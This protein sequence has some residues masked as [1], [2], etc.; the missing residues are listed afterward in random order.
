MTP[1]SSFTEGEI[2]ALASR[3]LQKRL[4]TIDLSDL[5]NRSL[6]TRSMKTKMNSRIMAMGADPYEAL[7]VAREIDKL[8]RFQSDGLQC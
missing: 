5:K 3:G 4:S 2:A 7:E 1:K 6:R 8:V